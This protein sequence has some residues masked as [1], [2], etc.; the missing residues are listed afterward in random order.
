MDAAL[1]GTTG[2]ATSNGGAFN[3]LDAGSSNN[4]S[5]IVGIDTTSVGAKSGSVAVSLTSNG[6]G[7]SGLG[8]TAL[9]SQN[10]NVSG[11]V[12]GFA[13]A[14]IDEST[15]DFVMRRGESSVGQT[16]NISNIA[17]ADGFHEGLDSN[18][19]NLADG[20]GIVGG[21]ASNTVAIR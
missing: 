12:F 19:A 14:A 8:L 9:T 17:A 16:F 10:I 21:D 2:D 20:Y 13:A 5:L 1:G 7:I 11:N 4:T 3:A 6:D 15:L 18:L